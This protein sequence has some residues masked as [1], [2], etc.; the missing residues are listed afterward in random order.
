MVL[1]WKK[2]ETIER[3]LSEYFEQCDLCYE[4]F[5]KAFACYFSV[6]QGEAFEASV[7]RTHEAESR[8]DDLRREI[9]FTLY[10]KALLPESRGDLL[11]LLEAF[12]QLPNIAET[13]LFAVRCQGMILPEDLAGD[14]KHLIDLN[15][16]AYYLVRRAVDE[17]FNNPKVTLHTTKEVDDKESE[18]DR[19]ERVMIRRIFARDTDNGTKLLLKELVLLIGRISDTAESTADRISIIAIKRQI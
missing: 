18:S 17:L 6:G 14:F 15:L 11:G 5:E 10:G 9:E 8:A 1:F 3:M 13:S 4:L 16:Q 12:D 7:N 2:Q 19:L